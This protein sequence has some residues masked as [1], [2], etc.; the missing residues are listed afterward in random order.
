[1]RILNGRTILENTHIGHN[2]VSVVDY[3][4]ASEAF[5]L[6]NSINS[7]PVNDLTTLSDHRHLQ[8]QLVKTT[9]NKQEE[10]QPTCLLPKPVN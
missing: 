9:I 8:I 10:N 7:F 4:L 5:L 2:G 1:M 3:V 6:K